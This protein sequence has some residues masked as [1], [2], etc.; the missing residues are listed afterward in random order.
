MFLF[1]K[2]FSSVKRC[3]RWN[4][5][6]KVAR[7]QFNR[8]AFKL[9]HSANERKWIQDARKRCGKMGSEVLMTQVKYFRSS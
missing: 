1:L 2:A 4:G 7:I 8:N 9:N 3:L 6:D 5:R